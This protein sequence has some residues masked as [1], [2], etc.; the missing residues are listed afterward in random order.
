MALAFAASDEEESTEKAALLEQKRWQEV[1]PSEEE[2]E[3]RASQAAPSQEDQEESRASQAAP[4]DHQQECGDDDSTELFMM[5]APY[6]TIQERAMFL[7]MSSMS[8]KAAFRKQKWWPEAASPDKEKDERAS[9]AALPDPQEE[10]EP[11]V[12]MELFR[13]AVRQ[14]VPEDSDKEPMHVGFECST[15]AAEEWHYAQQ[16]DEFSECLE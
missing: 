8:E 15:G 7:G 10:A 9:Q 14:P 1:A 4:S 11:Q 13:Q 6:L 3:E 12:G 5:V 16:D 2:V